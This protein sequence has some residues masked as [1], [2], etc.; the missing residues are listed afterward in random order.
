MQ[1]RARGETAWSNADLRETRLISDRIKCEQSRSM[2]SSFSRITWHRQLITFRSTMYALLALTSSSSDHY[3]APVLSTRN[4]KRYP[5][6]VSLIALGLQDDFRRVSR[7][8]AC[9]SIG[10]MKPLIVQNFCGRATLFQNSGSAARTEPL[11]EHYDYECSI[12]SILEVRKGRHTESTRPAAAYS[13]WHHWL[14]KEALGV[15]AR[16]SRGDAILDEASVRRLRSTRM[17]RPPGG[18]YCST[19]QPSAISANAHSGHSPHV[20]MQCQ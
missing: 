15:A 2:E 18:S 9:R 4:Q 16:R 7:R 5:V 6:E 10:E 3:A 11:G 19:R 12:T 17:R 20:V 13:Y 1:Q 8:D 14:R